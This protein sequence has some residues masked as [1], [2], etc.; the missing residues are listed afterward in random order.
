MR[1]RFFF[2]VAAI[3]AALA[4]AGTALPALAGEIGFSPLPQH[5]AAGVT[6]SLDQSSALS[7][8]APEATAAKKTT[9]NKTTA[10]AQPTLRSWMHGDL[11]SA[12]AAGFRGQG[13]TITVVDDFSSNSRYS[14]NLGTGK[15]SLRHG[16]WTRLEASMV[17][18][19]ATMASHDFNSGRS[20]ALARNRLNVLNLSY[21]MMAQA[22]YTASQIRWSAQENSII[23]YARNGSAVISKAAGNDAVAVGTANRS[24]NVDYLNLAL[25]GTASALY[26][27]ALD[28]NG[29]LDNKANLASYSN[30]AGNDATIQ[31]QFLTVGVTGNLTNLYGTSFA[32]PVVSGYAA[33]LGSKFTTATPVQIS[34]RLLDTA[35]TDTINNYSASVHGRGE[36]SLSRAI[37]PASIR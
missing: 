25:A 4:G 21:G 23:T 12:W 30:F 2:H 13:V 15:Q 3:C 27:G 24:G 31:R 10:A 33:V 36:A 28:R 16:E 5:P 34:N 19:S 8:V 20:V 11:A 1:S 18:P 17:A 26:V 9:T 29:S 35:R 32:A 6:F 14:G 37:A 22:G 7:F